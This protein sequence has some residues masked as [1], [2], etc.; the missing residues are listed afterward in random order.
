MVTKYGYLDWMP[1]PEHPDSESQ[2]PAF[3][4]LILHPCR[5]P[6]PQQP[7]KVRFLSAAL[8]GTTD[9]TEVARFGEKHLD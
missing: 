8:S 3:E 9:F 6:D 4:P 5:L 2:S 7:G 1:D